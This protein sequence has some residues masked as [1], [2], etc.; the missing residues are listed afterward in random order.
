MAGANR[1]PLHYSLRGLALLLGA[2]LGLILA[3][4]SRRDTPSAVFYLDPWR[5]WN[6]ALIIDSLGNAPKPFAECLLEIA[7]T[8]PKF[9]RVDDLGRWAPTY[10]VGSPAVARFSA[11]DDSSTHGLKLYSLFARR[12]DAYVKCTGADNPVGQVLVKESW[13][14]EPVAD[15]NERLQLIT[16]TFRL[17]PGEGSSGTGRWVRDEFMPCARKGGKLYRAAQKADLFIMFKVKP[18]NPDTDK[19]WVYGTVTADGKQVTSCGRV[20][21]CMHCHQRAPRDRL[22]GLP[23]D[24]PEPEPADGPPP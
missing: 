4:S 5:E 3:L 14:P 1:S 2:A 23:K 15:E 24:A 12:H 20:A 7:H 16:N 19:G 8:Y 22:F 17:E 10:C 9:G 21:S 18:D 6:Q 13:V 11:S